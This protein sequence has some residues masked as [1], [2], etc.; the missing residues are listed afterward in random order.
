MNRHASTSRPWQEVELGD[1]CQFAYG[2]SLPAKHRSG[3][4]YPVYGSNGPVGSHN[5]ALT[6][7]ETIIVGRKGSLGEVHFCPGP[8]SP[9]D[10]TYFI[11]QQQT[12]AHLPWLARRLHGLGLTKLNRAA[13]VP[14]L[15]RED[16][17]RQ[18]LLLPPLAEQK[19]IAKIL[20]AADALRAKRRESLA[21]LDELLRSAFLDMFGKSLDET[22][23]TVRSLGEHLRFVTSGG[24]G[25]AKYYSHHG[26]RFIRSLDVRMNEISDE[27]AILVE[28]PN[29]AE[30]RRTCVERDDV[31]LT[32]TGSR[33]GR[34]SRVR[35]DLSGAYIS[36]HVAILRVDDNLSAEY[37]ARFLALQCG[38]QRQIRRLQYG[39]T[40]PGLNF[41]QIRSLR[42]PV[43]PLSEQLRYV[44]VVRVVEAQ[45]RAQRSHLHALEQLFGSLQHRAFRGEL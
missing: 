42:L 43:P 40:K 45:R 30:A 1:V 36:Q 5:Q 11:T 21:L 41:K 2:K 29:N 37:L 35:D 4:G 7:G 25:W 15:N 23:Y 38:G 3:S 8:C 13:A 18:R 31:L 26:A 27:D 9:I 16:A 34:A 32:I 28:P 24:R 14:G 44:E 19:R 17:Y 39:Q 6:S 33:I 10:T 12:D 20:D 22:P